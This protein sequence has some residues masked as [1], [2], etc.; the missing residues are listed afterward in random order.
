MT[1]NEKDPAY[2][3]AFIE[4][5]EKIDELLDEALSESMRIWWLATA[6]GFVEVPWLMSEIPVDIFEAS[7]KIKEIQKIIGEDDDGNNEDF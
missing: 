3:K 5:V 6:S 2:Q 4:A 1:F 7:R